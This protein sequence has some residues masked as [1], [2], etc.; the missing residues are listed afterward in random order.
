MGPRHEKPVHRRLPRGQ[1]SVRFRDRERA[2]GVELH[3]AVV[4]AQ[5]TDRFESNTEQTNQIPRCGPVRYF[6][7]LVSIFTQMKKQFHLYL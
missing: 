6:N 2:V 4:D 3:L 1:G 7:G 5:N